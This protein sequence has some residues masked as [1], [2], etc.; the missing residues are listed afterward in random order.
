M[1]TPSIVRRA[2]REAIRPRTRPVASARGSHPAAR[3]RDAAHPRRGPR[4]RSA[5]RAT[6]T[7]GR[8]TC[9]R[10]ATSCSAAWRA[11]TGC[12][13]CR[14]TASTTS[15]ST[16]R[17][18][19]SG[20][21]RTSRSATTT[22]TSR[23]ARGA[24]SRSATRRAC[25]PR[26]P[27]T[28]LGPAPGG[29]PPGRR[30]ATASSARAAG[31]PSG[32]STLLGTDVHGATIGIVGFGRIGQAVARRAAG[33]GMRVLYHARNRVAEDVERETGATLGAAARPPRGRRLRLAPRQPGRRDPP[34]D[35]RPGPRDDAPVGD[36]REHGARPGRGHGR[37]RGRAADRHDPGRGA[38]RHRSRSR[39]RRTTRWWAWTTAWSC[40]T[41]APRPG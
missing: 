12:S 8:T 39:C 17:A 2:S 15:S 10:R 24:G 9:R 4:A 14:R 26:P 37:P 34:P 32:P 35:R 23:P 1:D 21:S 13:R 29:G 41:S 7:S 20:W 31:G 25:S 22:S 38:R 33:F 3:A 27:R 16:R 19:D 18:P 36:P 30:R 5:R 28:S 6:S 11:S 40:P